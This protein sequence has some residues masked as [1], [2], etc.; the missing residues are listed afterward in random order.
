MTT[1]SS[2]VEDYVKAVY[3]LGEEER[4][5]GDDAV[6]ATTSLARRLRVSAASATNMLKKLDS[7]G[8]VEHLPYRG[9]KLTDRGRAVALEVIRH[10]RLLETYLATALGVPWDEVHSEAEVLEH[11]LS[12]DLEERI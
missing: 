1:T 12:E 4:T 5:Q 8:L 2:A 7:L 9:A 10:H 11:V 6:V 3:L